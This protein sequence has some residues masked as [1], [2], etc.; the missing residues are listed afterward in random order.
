[1]VRVYPAPIVRRAKD[2]KSGSNGRQAGE[3]E[4]YAS[5][6]AHT[7][8]RILRRPSTFGATRIPESLPGAPM[9]VLLRRCRIPFHVAQPR[10]G[11]LSLSERTK[12]TVP[13]MTCDRAFGLWTTNIGRLPC[14]S[15]WLPSHCSGLGRQLRSQ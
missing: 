15:C 11:L 9:I 3:L 13:R 8:E 5:D 7:F 2:Y 10:V 14:G 12:D 6:I 4:G 1:M